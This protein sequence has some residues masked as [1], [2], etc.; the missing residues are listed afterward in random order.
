VHTCGAGIGTKLGMTLIEV[1]LLDDY[2]FGGEKS[3]SG[4]VNINILKRL[5]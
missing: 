4:T 2:C 1:A 3:G 5:G